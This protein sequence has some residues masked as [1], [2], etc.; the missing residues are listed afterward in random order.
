LDPVQNNAFVD[1]YL[2]V[3]FDLSKVLFVATGNS[4]N[5]QAALKDRMVCSLVALFFFFFFPTLVLQELIEVPGYS[6]DEKT[7]IL[8]KHLL[9]KQLKQ[10][11]MEVCNEL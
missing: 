4:S 1:N 10:H 9:P 6:M 2:G 11:G 7:E 5:I 8:K 3:P